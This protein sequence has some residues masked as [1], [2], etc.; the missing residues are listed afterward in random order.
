MGPQIVP[1]GVNP[2]RTARL[3]MPLGAF[4]RPQNSRAGIAELINS[5]YNLWQSD[6]MV[7]QRLCRGFAWMPMGYGFPHSV[8]GRLG[9]R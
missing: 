8:G 6:G 7:C 2:W 1:R 3:P 9:A 4:S 5:C